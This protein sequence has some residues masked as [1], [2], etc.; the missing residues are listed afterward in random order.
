MGKSYD[1]GHHGDELYV[2]MDGHKLYEYALKTVPL[3]AKESIEK[4]GVGIN[5]IK[6]VLIHQANEKMD[7]AILKRLF[8]LCGGE[9]QAEVMPMIIS[10]LG[11]NSVAT[12]PTL[13]DLI[14]KGKMNGHQIVSGDIIV[15]TSVGAGMNINSVV[16]R[17]A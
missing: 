7:E 13:L 15:L 8:K 10:W 5:D 17:L 2:K 4:A 12:V 16:Y 11:N 3:V 1:P 6:K 9:Y 14:L